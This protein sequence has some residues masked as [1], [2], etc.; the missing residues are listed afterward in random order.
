MAGEI[1]LQHVAVLV[2]GRS[3][4]RAAAFDDSETMLVDHARTLPFADFER[5]VQYW[6]QLADPHTAASDARR[7]IESRRL[8]LSKTF[9]GVGVLDGTLDPLRYAVVAGELDRLE[10]HEFEQDWAAARAEHGD[11]ATA[12]DLPR[13]AAQRRADALVL[14]AERSAS[15][16]AG[17]RKPVP[18]VN[19]HLDWATFCAELAACAQHPSGADRTIPDPGMQDAVGAGGRRGPRL[20]ESDDGTVLL[21]SQVLEQALRG[22]VRRVVFGPDGHILDFGRTKRLYDGGVRQA[23]QVRDRHCTAPGCDVPAKRCEVDH[24]LPW[25]RGGTTSESNG[26]LL[27]DR[28]N[29]SRPEADP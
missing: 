7:Q 9:D 25:A 29:R 10:Q 15:A 12:A 2:R 28:H 5:A 6:C 24:V 21:P 23:I 4:E 27:C 26:R 22:E 17:A 18:V 11:A 20:S 1:S 16:P 14:M 13:T 19:L 8:H 3:P